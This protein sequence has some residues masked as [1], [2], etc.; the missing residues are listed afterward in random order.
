MSASPGL[1]T[2]PYCDA[3]IALNDCPIVATNRTQDH[4]Q[5][6]WRPSPPRKPERRPDRTWWQRLWDM[7]ALLAQLSEPDKLDEPETVRPVSAYGFPRQD[8]PARACPRCGTPLPDD[9]AERPVRKIGIVGTTGAGKSQ[10]LRALLTE[11]GEQQ[12]L[13]CWGVTDFQIDEDSAARL[14]D[15]YHSVP[16]VRPTDP[17]DAPEANRRPFVVR[18]TLGTEKVLLFFYDI[19]GETLLD[20]RRRARNAPF[21]YRPA[22]LIFLIDP[23]MIGPVRKLLPAD[24]GRPRLVRQS[25]LV[26]ACIADLGERAAETPIAIV[27]TKSDLIEEAQVER[28]QFVLRQRPGDDAPVPHREA[29]MRVINGEVRGIFRS[30]GLHDLLA[31]ADRLGHTARLTFHAVAAIGFTPQ[32]S[33]APEAQKAEPL[34]CLEPLVAVLSAD[35]F[36]E[37]IK[38][39]AG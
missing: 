9:I 25:T 15:Q 34:R 18:A 23:M 26:S 5:V 21:L 24:P 16:D 37:R 39:S 4:C 29:E 38:G 1:V 7:L 11:A 33:G 12:K 35:W 13:S 10:F 19:D 36:R 31:L 3:R 32:T 6:L 27:L 2:C 20:R 17:A 28:Y 14:R 30:V 8:L 22:G